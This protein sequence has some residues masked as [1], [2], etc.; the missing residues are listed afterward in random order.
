MKQLLSLVAVLAL[1]VPV[2]AAQPTPVPIAISAP[3]PSA[4]DAERGIVTYRLRSAVDYVQAATLAMQRSQTP[5]VRDFATKLV[6]EQTAAAEQ[7]LA[8][9]R[10]IGAPGVAMTPSEAG[11][12]QLAHLARYRGDRFDEAFLRTVAIA[13]EHEIALVRE[14]TIVVQAPVVAQFLTA[15]LPQL[16][17]HLHVAQ[18]ALDEVARAQR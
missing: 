15:A 7:A 10:Q 17:D 16:E 4:R 8:L 13:H 5:A 14:A 6:T 3:K 12:V 9:G 1:A 11:A 18:R 2:D